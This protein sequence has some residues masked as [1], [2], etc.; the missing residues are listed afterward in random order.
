MRITFDS[1]VMSIAE[2]YPTPGIGISPPHFVGNLETNADAS[3]S[4]FFLLL[5][6]K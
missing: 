2:A 3:R 4:Y 6:E 1:S 5:Q